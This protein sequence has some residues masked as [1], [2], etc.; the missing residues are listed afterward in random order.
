MIRERFDISADDSK[1]VRQVA[2]RSLSMS[3]PYCWEKM[4][5]LNYLRTMIPVINRYNESKEER[6]EGYKR[7]WE[8]FNTTPTVSGFISGLSASMEKQA[9]EDKSFDRASINAVKTSLMGP[10]AGIGDSIFQSTWR[11]ISTGI[12]IGFAQQGNILGPIL[13]LLIYNIPAT[14]VRYLGPYIGFG[15]G[16]KFMESAAENGILGFIT[17]AA[18]IVGLMTVGAMTSSM[19]NLEIAY[20]FEMNGAEQSIQSMIDTIFPKLLPLLLVLVCFR[21]LNKKVKPT[22]LIFSLM[23]LGILLHVV[24]I[25]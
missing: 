22:I 12:A 5:A 18:S 14:I 7:H 4:Q 16:S 19:V 3:A 17:K 8:L 23:G 10:L 9:S 21:L 1:M 2:Y 25:L 24:G 15:L 13:F 6:I 11:V 20:V